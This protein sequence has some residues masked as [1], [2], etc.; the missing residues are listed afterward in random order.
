MIENAH[1]ICTV[2]P[3]YAISKTVRR[4]LDGVNC[5]SSTAPAADV[6]EVVIRN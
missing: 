1:A 4:I 3:A 2:D 6:T 5:L